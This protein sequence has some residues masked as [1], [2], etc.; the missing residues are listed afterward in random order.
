VKIFLTLIILIAST[1]AQG[2]EFHDVKM[3]DEEAVA[4]QKL[5]LKG[6]G[7]REINILAIYIRVYVA[8]LYVDDT[9]LAC[10]KIIE[11]GN[12]KMIK[13][14]FL[15]HVS[16]ADLAESLEKGIAS[17][18]GDKCKELVPR[19]KE[20]KALVPG[21]STGDIVKIIFDSKGTG[22]E[23]NDKPLGRIEGRDFSKTLL[24]AFIG[25]VPPTEDLK[26]GLCGK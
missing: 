1:F 3:A 24:S 11:S 21:P 23:F 12:T 16:P 25:K 15:R 20:V 7:L 14:S 9:K 4:G 13:M 6:M 18:C 22:F 19:A 5:H 26:N 8:G 2:K 10:D 17:N